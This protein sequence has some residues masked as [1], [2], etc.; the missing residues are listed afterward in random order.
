LATRGLH[1]LTYE[2]IDHGCL[3]APVLFDL[4]RIPDDHFI[5]DLLDRARV[6]DLGE[7]FALHDDARRLA[8]GEHLWKN[9]FSELV[10]NLAFAYERDQF[11]QMGRRDGRFGYVLPGRV[12]SAGKIAHHPVGGRARI[13]GR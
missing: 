9:L 13:P 7:S 5:E 11:A 6:A 8:A 12:Q 3:A 2:E 4:L 10:R 1:N